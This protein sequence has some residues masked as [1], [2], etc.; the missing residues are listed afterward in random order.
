M[1]ETF[2]I[3]AA[4][5]ILVYGLVSAVT[6]K[7]I[8]TPHMV[9]MLVGVLC[10]PL[11]L[12]L[13]DLKMET[14]AVEL[15]ATVALVII[16][17][18]DASQADKKVLR[19]ASSLPVR[20]LF[21]GLPLTILA[22]IGIGMLSFPA[23]PMAAVIYLA[24]VLAPTDAALG[25]AVISNEAVPVKIREAL[26]VESGLNDGICL[27]AIFAVL[28]YL[29]ADL[30]APDSPHWIKF[31]AM[32]ILLGPVAG[33]IV[34]I[35]GGRLI[36]YAAGRGWI[37]GSIQRLLLPALAILA[38]ALAEAI[39]GNGF[40]GAFFAGFTLSVKNESV[41]KETQDFS[42]SEGT[43]LSLLTFLIL[44]LVMIP[45]TL[46]HWNLQTTIYA[47]LSLTVIRMVPVALCLFG[48]KLDW[49]TLLFM[50]WF[51]PRGIAS[52]L[53][54]LMLVD[55]LGVKGYEIVI[56]TGVQAVVLS[57][58]LHGIT[59]APW[60]KKYGASEAAAKT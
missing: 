2:L 34:G 32:Q 36:D 21:I 60:A 53:Y 7:S 12:N 10:S 51:G 42:E 23:L 39:G 27:P 45:A 22:G 20:L 35:G 1:N 5:L 58:L 14:P 29:G 16:L 26:N 57:V 38:Y 40:I 9:F 59:A 47:L 24:L 6:E 11:A 55:N 13:I 33:A 31:A 4:G 44:G 50:G 43:I 54:L 30:G 56:A 19:K 17:A 3:L 37:E 25:Q 28:Y 15:L 18:A 8:L 52:I 46:S 48:C 49:K 41:R